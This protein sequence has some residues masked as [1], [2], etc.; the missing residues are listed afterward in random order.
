MH[1]SQIG[2]RLNKILTSVLLAILLTGCSTNTAQY[3]GSAS[4]KMA[5]HTTILDHQTHRSSSG[6]SQ[7]PSS[8]NFEYQEIITQ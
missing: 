5:H 2:E 6:N 1:G 8:V 4:M 7:N 3:F